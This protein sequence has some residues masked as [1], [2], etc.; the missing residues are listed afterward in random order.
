MKPIESA[1]AATLDNQ[2]LNP[3]ELEAALD[4]LRHLCSWCEKARAI[5]D[6]C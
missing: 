2:K 4:S 3:E 5:E 1:I 6:A